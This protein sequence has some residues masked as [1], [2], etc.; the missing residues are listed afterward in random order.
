MI[1]N[2]KTG[3]GDNISETDATAH[4]KSNIALERTVCHVNGAHIENCRDIFISTRTPTNPHLH[5]AVRTAIMFD[6]A[7]FTF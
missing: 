3:R 6:R 4:S 1:S 5:S 7:I 2:S